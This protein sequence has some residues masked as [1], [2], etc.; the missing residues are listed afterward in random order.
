[1]QE[2]NISYQNLKNQKKFLTTSKFLYENKKPYQN[3]G[4]AKT[5]LK[6]ER[7]LE[8]IE[9]ARYN[10]NYYITFFGLMLVMEKLNLDK[11]VKVDELSLLIDL[12][13][14]KDFI[15]MFGAEAVGPETLVTLNAIGSNP[16]QTKHKVWYDNNGNE[17][18]REPLFP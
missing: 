18:K 10:I 6:T 16:R 14:H 5:I 4:M 8:E 9:E 7:L 12:I 17:I 3:D 15:R 1:M 13:S 2:L 11:Y